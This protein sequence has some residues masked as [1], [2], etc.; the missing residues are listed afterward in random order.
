MSPSAHVYVQINKLKGEVK[1]LT[2]ALEIAN[3]VAEQAISERDDALHQA[4][5]YYHAVETAASMVKQADA[6][7]SAS[8]LKLLAVSQADAAAVSS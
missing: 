5:R 3:G 2:E 6:D 4:E 8:L 7:L 1:R